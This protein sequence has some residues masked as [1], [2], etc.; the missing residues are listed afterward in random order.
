LFVLLFEKNCYK[1]RQRKKKETIHTFKKKEGEYNRHRD[2]QK[3]QKIKLWIIIIPM[4]DLENRQTFIK[5]N[6]QTYIHT[7]KINSKRRL[8][9]RVKRKMLIHNFVF[10]NRAIIK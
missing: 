1:H 10:L 4:M 2:I 6:T 5:K 7:N 3:T 8:C 9:S